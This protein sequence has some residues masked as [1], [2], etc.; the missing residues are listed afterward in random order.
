MV[1]LLRFAVPMIVVADSGQRVPR[2]ADPTPDSTPPSTEVSNDTTG[3]DVETTPSS[4]PSTTEGSTDSNTGSRQVIAI[5]LGTLAAMFVV[6]LSLST[7]TSLVVVWGCKISRRRRI[8]RDLVLRTKHDIFEGVPNFT[9]SGSSGE[10]PFH[11]VLDSSSPTAL[12]GT[13]SGV[14]E[15]TAGT[16][17]STSVGVATDTQ[18]DGSNTGAGEH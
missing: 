11:N 15:L 8:E 13:E 3:G 12:I 5:L 9:T 6:V 7:I 2:Q 18:Q 17:K 4:L 1:T 14:F 16:T 10:N